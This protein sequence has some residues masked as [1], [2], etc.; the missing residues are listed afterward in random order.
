LAGVILVGEDAG[1]VQED[2]L[3]AS[4]ILVGLVLEVGNGVVI[5]LDERVSG[6]STRDEVFRFGWSGL[7]EAR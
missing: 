7:A 4:V 6:A 5:P 2:E 3:A 1:V